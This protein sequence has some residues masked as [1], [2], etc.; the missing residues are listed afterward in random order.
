MSTNENIRASKLKQVVSDIGGLKSVG[1]TTS[2]ISKTFNDAALRK[3]QTD[4]PEFPTHN[5]NYCHFL[6]KSASFQEQIALH[7]AS[8]QKKVH[9]TSWLQ[10][11]QVVIIVRILDDSMFNMLNYTLTTMT[12]GW[13]LCRLSRRRTR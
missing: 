12:T 6:H 3:Q 11:F 1:N 5:A 8:M 4:D 9:H 2:R 13:G 10:F 7:G